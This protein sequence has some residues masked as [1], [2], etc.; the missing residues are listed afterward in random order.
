MSED[1]FYDRT[2]NLSG[3]QILD[4]FDYVPV[5]GSSVTFESKNLQFDN[6]DNYFQ[7]IPQG[8]NNLRGK[9]SLKYHVNEGDAQ[10]LANYYESSEGVNWVDIKTDP[11][12]YQDIYGYCTE[13]S[14]THINNQ[15]HEFSVMIE[16]VETPGVI[17]W[18]GMNYL[19]PD[20]DNWQNS[21]AYKKYDIVYTGVNDSKLDNFYYCTE[22]HTSTTDNSPTGNNSSWTQEFFWEPDLNTS[23]PVKLDVVRYEGGF[24]VFN[25]IKKNTAKLETQYSFSSISTKQLKSMLHFLENKAG[26]RRFKHYLPK[27]FNR[28]K[29]YICPSWQHTWVYDN[30]HNLSVNFQEDPMGVLPKNS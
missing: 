27:V 16:S 10:K 28:P 2:N 9:F 12:V 20:F 29:V 1:L 21:Q 18:S 30:S 7:L 19:S 6:H 13:Y 23:S 17:N 24:D 11:S 22:D 14:I 5:Y 15:R 3:I 26:Y 25:K 8:I 4:G